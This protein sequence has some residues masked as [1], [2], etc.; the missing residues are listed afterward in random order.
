MGRKRIDPDKKKVPY[1]I[2]ISQ[3]DLKFIREHA[4]QEGVTVSS[5]F[6]SMIKQY[7]MEKRNELTKKD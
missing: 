4:E 5:I 6:T 1:P 3:S 2:S 7:I